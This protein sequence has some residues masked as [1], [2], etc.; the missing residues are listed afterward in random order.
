V[1]DPAPAV[2]PSRFKAPELQVR[3]IATAGLQLGSR[4]CVL[5]GLFRLSAGPR[6]QPKDQPPHHR[7]RCK[8][9]TSSQGLSPPT[10]AR[11]FPAT[12]TL[13]AVPLIEISASRAWAVGESDGSPLCMPNLHLNHREAQGWA[14]RPRLISR[15]SAA[16]APSHQTRRA[17]LRLKRARV[18][19]P[20]SGRRGVS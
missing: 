13:K 9:R 7:Q 4:C 8:S 20:P 1:L 18:T 6:I 19:S 14:Y 12:R 3:P 11:G 10:A 5:S 16:G 2:S 15:F 17:P